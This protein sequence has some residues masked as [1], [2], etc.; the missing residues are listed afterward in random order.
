MHEVPHMVFCNDLKE[1]RTAKLKLNTTIFP[2]VHL[3]L[4]PLHSCLLRLQEMSC[5]AAAFPLVLS[6]LPS[7]A[8]NVLSPLQT[9]SYTHNTPCFSLTL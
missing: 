3:D 4:I 8:V 6:P 2:L 7:S 9:P 1:G 5:W